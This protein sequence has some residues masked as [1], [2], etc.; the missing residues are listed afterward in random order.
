MTT[1]RARKK[2]ARALA[3]AENIPYSQALAR[4]TPPAAAAA[5]AGEDAHGDG[6]RYI[7]QPTEAEA[8]VG[9]VA[10]DLG[11]RALAPDSTPEHRAAAEAT[12]RPAE[13]DAPCRCSGSCRHGTACEEEFEEAD[14]EGPAAQ[15]ATIPCGG[16]LVHVDRYPGSMWGITIWEDVY[17]CSECGETSTA[18]VTLPELP[19]GEQRPN[20][21]GEGFST[22]IY[23]GTRHAVL[24]VFEDDGYDDELAYPDPGCQECGAG[25]SGDPYGECDC[26]DEDDA[27]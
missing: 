12:W 9:I 15:V 25:G 1:Q 13:A 22:L 17:Q 24:D 19:W 20:A 10:A 26:Y 14:G 7:A 4:L 27:A 23:G 16:R 11:V 6:P 3:A 18:S 2:Q 5:A 8:A 21:S